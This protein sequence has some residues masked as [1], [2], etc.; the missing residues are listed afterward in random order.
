MACQDCADP[1]CTC[2]V[3]G[4]DGIT[5]VGGGSPTNPI[6]VS[7]EP[8]VVGCGL[9]GA[10]SEAAPLQPVVGAWPYDC[11]IEDTAGGVYCDAE[12][13]L[14]G[15]PLPVTDYVQSSINQ[16]VP[17][18]PVP[19]E[20]EIVY[21]HTLDI[22]NPSACRAARVIVESE[23]DVDFTFP[24]GGRGA[25][26]VAGDEM[27]RYTNPGSI[28]VTNTHTQATKVVGNVVVPAGG[29]TTFN[30]PIGL[31]AGAGGATYNRVQVFLRA[32]IFAL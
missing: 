24:P 1:R 22:P 19:A 18:L 13:R 3:I 30:L 29:T 21:T 12:G 32:T 16:A 25:Y 11:P 9:E 6:V 4:G 26:V 28:T 8:L 31:T 27:F 5:V 2:T 17:N 20:L 23:T 15:E 10:G 14:R 7:R